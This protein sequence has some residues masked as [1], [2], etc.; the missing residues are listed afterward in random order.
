MSQAAGPA[1]KYVYRCLQLNPAKQSQE[2]LDQ[3]AAGLGLP[4]RLQEGG[5]DAEK[6]RRT[7]RQKIQQELD[8]I[9]S[10]FWTA[11]SAHLHAQLGRLDV[12]DFPELQKGVQR[13]LHLVGIRE[14]V[15]GMV[16]MPSANSNL[17][18]TVKRIMMLPPIEAGRVKD[19]FLFAL[20]FHAELSSVKATVRMLISRF[21]QVYQVER[22]WFDQILATKSGRQYVARAYGE[23]SSGGSL[24]QEMNY[25]IFAIIFVLMMLARIMHSL[26][27]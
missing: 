18:N 25:S 24:G 27:R 20:P 22:A 23:S 12:S 13:M 2:I 3:R 15:N 9:R 11:H 26:T 6:K 14:Q 10:V 1:L 8:S 7:Q 19:E 4:T 5:A 21:P 16:G 17:V